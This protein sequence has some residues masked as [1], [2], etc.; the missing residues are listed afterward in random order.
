MNSGK[1]QI[2][3]FHYGQDDYY[4]A[5]NKQDDDPTAIG[6][7]IFVTRGDWRTAQPDIIASAVGN[8]ADEAPFPNADAYFNTLL[9]QVNTQR[10]EYFKPKPEPDPWAQKLVDNITGLILI[11]SKGLQ[12]RER[13]WG[14]DVPRNKWMAQR[15]GYSGDFG[16]GGFNTWCA[17]NG[18]DVN[19]LNAE[20]E[21]QK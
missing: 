16:S 5:C 19:A 17:A 14:G 8:S 4:I 18:W 6:Y 9:G 3:K 12:A 1:H 11:P 15:T 20:Y 21:A 10:V 7:F 13:V 2:A